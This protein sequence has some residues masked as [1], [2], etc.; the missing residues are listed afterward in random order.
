MLLISLRDNE[1]G[2]F[3][4]PMVVQT[5]GIAMREVMDQVRRGGPENLLTMHPKDFSVYKLAEWNPDTGELTGATGALFHA[6][7]LFDV[8]DVVQAHEAKTV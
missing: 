7:R 2:L 3:H 5:V 6:E 1:A 4:T 8:I